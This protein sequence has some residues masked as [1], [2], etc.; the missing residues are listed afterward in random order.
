[1]NTLYGLLLHSSGLSVQEAA[2]EHGVSEQ[3]VID[4]SCGKA[5][6]SAKALQ[7]LYRLV[8]LQDHA[9]R[10][11]LHVLTERAQESVRICIA[12]DVHRR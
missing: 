12:D 8:D 3:T 9:A 6:A 4:W 1:M 11:L 5:A 7:Y 2:S 10:W